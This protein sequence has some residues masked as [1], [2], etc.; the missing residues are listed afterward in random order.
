MSDAG[1]PG[2]FG[3]VTRECSGH[4]WTVVGLAAVVVVLSILA[5]GRLKVS[6]SLEAMF[7]LQSPAAAAMHRLTTSYQASEA[8]LIVAEKLGEGAP[9][10]TD[11]ADLVAFAERFTTGLTSDPRTRERVLYARY[12]QDPAYAA[13]VREVVLPN[14]PFYFGPEATQELIDRLSPRRLDEQFAR[15]EALIASPGPAGSAISGAVLR[16]PLRLI[17][18]VPRT[19]STAPISL[20]AEP[21]GP[22]PPEFSRDGRALLI[23]VAAKG[24]INDVEEAAEL[25]ALA[26]RI[27]DESNRESL[28]VRAGGPY[29]ISA[30][31]SRTIRTDTI[32]STLA[33]IGLLYALF[34]V[35]YRRWI[36]PI[37]IGL[38]AGAGLLA[39]FGAHALTAPTVS[40]LAA[41]VAA[42][43]A[44]LGVDYGIHF[45]SH[46]DDLRARG[47]PP[48]EAAVE[49]ARHMGVPIATN[50]F[51]SIFGF[52][53]LWPSKIAMLADFARL[54]AA[55]LV[56]SLV[57]AFTLL[58]AM[59]V[60]T[61]RRGEA[62]RT[63]PPRFGFVADVVGRRPRR[64]MWSSLAVLGVA[65]AGAGV[66]GFLPSLEGDLTVLHPRP[67]AAL[68]TTDE[69]ISR[70]VSQGEIIPVLV[71][72]ESSESLVAEAHATARALTA[73][74]C[75]R[76]GVADVLGL[77]T[78][79]PDPTRAQA[80]RG[81]LAT[82][83]AD[84]LLAGFDKALERSAFD[85]GVYAGYR[86]FLSRL[87]T[88]TA[89]PVTADLLRYPSIAQRLFPIDADRGGELAETVMLVRLSS[90]LRDRTR[91]GE[92]IGTLNAALEHQP[93]ATIAGLAAVSE[94]LEEA[95]RDGLPQAVLIS[96][97]LVLL[98]LMI[99]FRRPVDVL[100][101]LT[102]LIFA[103][104]FTVAFMVATRQRFNP[105][106]SIAIP[107]LDGIAVDAGVFLVSV[108][109]RAGR[110]PATFARDLRP[111]V[112]AVL[113]A[114]AT[115]VTGFV[116]L[117]ATHT[118]AIRSLG[119]VAAIG[120]AASLCGAIGLLVPLLLAR[121]RPRLEHKL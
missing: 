65:I 94:D 117:C 88:A 27:A 93:H 63:A 39:G 64:W 58:P 118:P 6:A 44:G 99:V 41:A 115:T 108:A 73:D 14:A 50:C 30:A 79:L 66:Q 97:G 116:S 111:T 91:R 92:V 43:L 4:P 72:A 10:P 57:A 89:P 95:T 53:S 32:V 102:P 106:N 2:P 1:R 7:G 83:N 121:A 46:F 56:G 18:L 54:S 19:G 22:A 61:D 48:R 103:G 28:A 113:L 3:T 114:V 59:L 37:R 86:S 52:A 80:V 42:L 45:S 119:L 76:I 5:L 90:P 68:T 84:T 74:A 105:I 16:D 110:D 112:H 29:A 13:F 81:I 26:R 77:H 15:N 107:L 17:E 9:S 82:A 67:N 36:T 21:S 98:W 11:Q 71:R 120:I 55:G 49:T 33:S 8:L 35:F 23:R 69:I 20:D 25:T 104:L 78:L 85:P 109:R 62:A 87:L 12:R 70:F 24:S 38:T 51:T 31:A 60:L 101:A 47:L 40:P 34:V 100:L 96:V 75:R